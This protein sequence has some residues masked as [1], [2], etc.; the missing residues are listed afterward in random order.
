M[1]VTRR[2][3]TGITIIG[4]M[5][6]VIHAVDRHDGTGLRSCGTAVRFG[7]TGGRGG[8]EGPGRGYPRS[9]RLDELYEMDWYVRLSGTVCRRL[10]VVQD[11]E[12]VSE[13]GSERARVHDVAAFAVKETGPYWLTATNGVEV[14][15]GACGD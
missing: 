8:G 5:V 1:V 15:T 10:Q 3:M 4:T 11:W 2:I 13:V 7:L 12:Q 9:E 14:E 6:V